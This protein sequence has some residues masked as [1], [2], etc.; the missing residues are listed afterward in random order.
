V[1][2]VGAHLRG[3]PL[4]HQLTDRGARWTGEAATAAAYR[5]VALDTEPAKPGLVRDTAAGTSIRGELWT[6]SPAALGEFLTALPTPMTLGAVELEDGRWTV[7]F[8]CDHEAVAAA[9]PLSVTHWLE[10]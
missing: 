6:L 4:M 9:E 8:A 10:R 5:L 2:V 3:Q 7:G 1:F